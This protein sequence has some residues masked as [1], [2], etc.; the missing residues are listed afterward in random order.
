[1]NKKYPTTLVWSDIFLGL[2]GAR[3]FKPKPKLKLANFS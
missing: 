1:M 2:V 3:K